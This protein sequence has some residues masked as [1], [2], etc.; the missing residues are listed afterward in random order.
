MHVLVIGG[1]GHVGRFLVPELVREG[2]EVSVLHSGRTPVPDRPEWSAVKEIRCD[3]AREKI[4]PKHLGIRPQVVVDFPGHLGRTV[5]AFADIAEHLIACGSIWMYGKP[6]VVPTPECFFSPCFSEGY[7]RRFEEMQSLFERFHDSGPAFTTIMPPNICGPGK[8]PLEG[9]GGRSIEVHKAHARGEEVPLPAGP[10]ALVGPCDA[11]DI[12][13]CFALA[14]ENRD[15]ARGQMFNVGSAY[16]LTAPAFI[17]ALG[18]AHGASIPIRWVS[19]EEYVTQISPD[20]G[21]YSHFEF[22]MCPD[23]SRARRLLGYEPKYTPEET[24]ERAVRWMR[25]EGMM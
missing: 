10:K 7:A 14:I 12:A 17:A 11:E 20:P 16:A 15:A 18:Q 9:M 19:W 5:E 3:Y 22:H 13:H 23:I 8:I 2:Y 1:T 25:D 24:I 6:T 4:D 21:A